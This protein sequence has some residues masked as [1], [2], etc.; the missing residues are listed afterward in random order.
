MGNP[1][2]GHGGCDHEGPPG[3]VCEEG[4]ECRAFQAHPAGNGCKAIPSGRRQSRN[5]VRFFD[6]TTSAPDP[7]GIPRPQP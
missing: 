7:K 1:L 5:A 2:A 6:F 4:F 3:D